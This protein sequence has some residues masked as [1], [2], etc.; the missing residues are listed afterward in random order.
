M[1]T[2][3]I[4]CAGIVLFLV[5]VLLGMSIAFSFA[6][7]GI[8]G[9]ILLKGLGPAMA[10]LGTAPLM[11]TASWGIV[12]IPLFVLMGQ[13]AYNAGISEDLYESAYKWMGRFPG[14]LVLATTL[15]CTGFAA[16]TGSSI[17]S[18]ATMSTLAYPE[19]KRYRYDDGWATGAIAAGGTLGP[20]I[21]PSV[22]FIVYGLISGTS[23]AQLFIAGILPGLLI[24]SLFLLIILVMFKRRPE[25]GPSCESFSW[26]ERIVSLKNVWGMAALFLAV[27]GGLYFGVITPSEAGALGAFGAFV[28]MAIR[29]K[30]TGKNFMKTFRET[31]HITCFILTVLIGAM[32]F[33]TFLVITGLPGSFASFLAGL[34]LSRFLILVVI[35][36]A[37][38][39]LGCIIDSLPMILLT[40]PI[41][42]PVVQ[43][44][45]FDQVW[46]G[47][48]VVV[49]CEISLITPPVGMNL[50]V[51]QGVTKVPLE[52]VV[53]GIIPFLCM[54]MIGLAILVAFPQ[55][56]LF[57]PGMMK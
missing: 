7:V 15:A 9:M 1:F 40:L 11:Y 23:V 27:V 32:I 25:L 21:P 48:L 19:M 6:T 16:C 36:L 35:L 39:P 12:S 28:V 2:I 18:A 8:L 3:M 5:L 30:L 47:V 29:G 52:T 46:F 43:A 13:F 37:Y 31:L 56:S 26:R 51:V 41:V 4:G 17:A 45:G 34:P 54:L 50:Y 10:L 24:S 44:L 55:I 57:L 14:G 53:R 38:I 20:L 42:C 33:S 49:E 22:L